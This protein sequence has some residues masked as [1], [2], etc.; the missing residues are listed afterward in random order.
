[1]SEPTN[2]PSLI[3]TP[4]NFLQKYVKPSP[5]RGKAFTKI[6]AAVFVGPQVRRL[7]IESHR[8]PEKLSEVEL[9]AWTSFVSLVKGFLG[10]H[11]A[12]NSREIVGKLV[13]TY[14]RMNGLPDVTEATRTTRPP[15]C[16]QRKHGRLLRRT[17]W[18]ISPGY[19]VFRGA[20]QGTVQWKYDGGLYLE[21]LAWK[22]T[23]IQS[24]I[25]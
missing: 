15:W 21:P 1:M 14:R 25:S 6:K 24:P 13:D 18:K 4:W 17:R 22:W 10:N 2:N 12:E 8:F 16:V 23:G 9:A 11:K 19:K 3:L 5:S 7:I 20:L